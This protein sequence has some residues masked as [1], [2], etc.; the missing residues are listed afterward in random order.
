[1]SVTAAIAADA[2]T[3]DYGT[4]KALDQVS[5]DIRPGECIALVGP[6]GAGKSTLFKL[7]LG[8]VPPSAGALSVL[9]CNPA[10][11]EFTT[12]KSRIGFLPEQAMFQ[13]ALSGTETLRFYARLKGADVALNDDILAR[14]HLSEAAG[15]R[16][17]TYSKGMRQRLGLAQALIG[18]P[19]ILLLDEPMSGLDP[20]ARRNFF[21]ILDEE[22]ARGAAIV[23]S[24]HILTELE[25]RT[26]RVAILS[27]GQLKAMGSIAELR[28][29]LNLH[30]RIRLNAGSQQMQ[31]LAG[32]F[33]GRFD[34]ACFMNGTAVLECAPE[35]KLEL[36][37]EL[38]SADL[39][40]ENIDILEPS[41]EQVFAVHTAGGNQ[42]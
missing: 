2:L 32:H 26:D 20:E 24:S 39:T 35:D 30:T 10:Q 5:L 4:L 12:L 33:E 25:A 18:A 31:R 19:D 16:V 34:R 23:L 28:A 3:K 41:L 6:N 15:R 11:G 40:F 17:G 42:S 29:K 14:V 36:L 21:Q 27:R 22:K 8:L 1:M 13:D 37:K 9:G 7:C 38:M